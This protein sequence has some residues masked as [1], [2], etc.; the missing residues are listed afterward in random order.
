MRVLSRRKFLAVCA[1]ALPAGA[2]LDSFYV[3]PGWLR[4]RT[5]RLNKEPSHRIVHFTDLHHKGDVEI[6]RRVVET[7]NSLRAD[8]VLFTGDLVEDKAHCRE[9]LEYFSRI[10]SPLYGVPGNHDYWARVNFREFAEVFS[11]T[12]GSWLMDKTIRGRDGKL[13]LIGHTCESSWLGMP[14]PGVKNIALFHYPVW[15]ERMEDRRFDL[16][17]AGH[18]HGGQVRL[19]FTGALV[20][21]YNTG[22]YDIGL[23]KTVSGPLYVNPGIGWFYMNMRFGCRPEITVFEV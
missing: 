4:V 12:G 10:E 15:V 20:L 19:P 14:E 5:V 6:L 11:K 8:A 9:A 13:N 23:F 3:E 16:M 22:R 18:T 7:I 17:L 21:P 2:L 1:A